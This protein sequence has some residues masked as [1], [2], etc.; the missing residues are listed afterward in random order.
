V[1][2]LGKQSCII[3]G[4]RRIKEAGEKH[5]FGIHN[6]VEAPNKLPTLLHENQHGKK[7]FILESIMELGHQTSCQLCCMKISCTDNNP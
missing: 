4:F 6:K 1:R 5:Y 2:G 3:D 7:N